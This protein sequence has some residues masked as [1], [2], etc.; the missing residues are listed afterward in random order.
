MLQWVLEE[1]VVLQDHE[2]RQLLQSSTS[3]H[4]L[5]VD[6]LKCLQPADSSAG[7]AHGA[8]SSCAHEN[9]ASLSD[10][11][12]PGQGEGKEEEEEDFGPWV[13]HSPLLQACKPGPEPPDASGLQKGVSIP[14]P[15]KYYVMNPICQDSLCGCV[16]SLQQHTVLLMWCSTLCC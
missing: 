5:V 14:N 15:P 16:S 13:D 3:H 4:H 2:V 11:D 7:R 8:D 12:A 6:D 1:E 9:Q 10:G